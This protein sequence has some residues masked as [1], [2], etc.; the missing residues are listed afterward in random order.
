MK[1]LLSQNMVIFNRNHLLQWSISPFI[2][3]GSEEV[4]AKRIGNSVTSSKGK[5]LCIPKGE[6]PRFNV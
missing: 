4:G 5:G 2:N 3:C 1:R 6:D